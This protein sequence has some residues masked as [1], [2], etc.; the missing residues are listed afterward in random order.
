MI[1]SSNGNGKSLWLYTGGIGGGDIKLVAAVDIA[2]TTHD[3]C[4]IKK[5]QYV[6]QKSICIILINGRKIINEYISEMWLISL[7]YYT[8]NFMV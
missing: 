5:C 8:I 6:L 3:L 1:Y 2:F 7:L 4:Q